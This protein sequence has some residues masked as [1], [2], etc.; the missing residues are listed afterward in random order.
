MLSCMPARRYHHGDLRAALL[1]RAEQ[2][3]RDRGAGALSL[4]ELARDLGVSHAAP[5]RHFRDKQ[6]LLDALALAGF[7]RLSEALERAAAT[8]GGF[9]ARLT[10]LARAYVDFAINDAELL[11]VMYAGKHD[12]QASEQLIGAV[13]RMST[14]LLHSITDA[15]AAGE[16]VAG[17]PIRIATVAATALH[18]F[19]M[20]TANGS[21]DPC[22]ADETLDDIVHHLLYGLTPR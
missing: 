5:S 7:E 22:T 9:R 17:D 3:L 1:V 8:G 12:P 20:F 6:A 19:A 14:V 11:E 21:L 4:R 15:Q 10:A 16:I 13:A 2:T 18:G